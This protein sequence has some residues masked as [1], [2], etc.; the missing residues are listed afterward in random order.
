[1]LSHPMLTAHPLN[2]QLQ[3]NPSRRIQLRRRP[4]RPSGGLQ[5][6]RHVLIALL[7]ILPHL[8]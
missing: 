6:L 5:L 7:L 2:A 4:S 3:S 8:V 1:M